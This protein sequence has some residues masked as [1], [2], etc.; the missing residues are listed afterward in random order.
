M[1]YL[2]R[3]AAQRLMEAE[4]LEALIL[5]S[6][7]AFAHATGASPG[8]ATM[9]RREGAVAVLVP[10]DAAVPET[11]VV[12]DL[13][14]AGLRRE[15][16]IEDI[17]ESP[18]WVEAMTLGDADPDAPLAPSFAGVWEADGRPAGNARPETFDPAVCYGH[19]RDALAE[20]GMR[21]A[22]VGVEFT[23]VSARGYPEL[24]AALAPAQLIDG[25]DI[26]R[27]LRA[28]KAPEEIALLRSAVQ[29]AETGIEAVRDAIA[30]GVSR[31]DLA[32]VW[33]EKVAVTGAETPMTGA[34]EY[35]SVGPDPWGGNAVATPGDLVKVDVGCLMRGYTSDSGRTFVV[36]SPRRL[37]TELHA[38]L[39]AGFHAGFDLLRPGV[40]LS[41]VH[42]A[43]QSAI[44]AKGLTG[45]SR[46]HFGHSLGTG[47]GSEEW[48]FISARAETRIESGMVLAF[49][50]PIYVTRLG[51][52]IIEDQV[53]ITEDGPV[54]MNRLPRDLVAC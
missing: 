47:P 41:E 28:V 12:S 34:W 10:A 24:S 7:E 6:A 18:I 44:R 43:A 33:S 17:R 8:V 39:M 30:A 22:R 5:F 16:H 53:E 3:E 13:F 35:I 15:S 38:A 32:A 9:W 42:R 48:P 45:Y 25:T 27:Q 2:N 14:A 46:G 26:A 54:S 52:M 37:Q 49:E 50:C 4:G 11:V 1:A 19:L 36:G 40:P 31:N 51:G 20:K 23:A 21:D 29:V